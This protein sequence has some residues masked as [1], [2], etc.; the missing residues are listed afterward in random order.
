MNLLTLQRNL[1]DHLIQGSED[2]SL[3][4]RGDSSSRLAVYYDAYR[5][6]LVDCLRDTFERVWTWLGDA[7]F[8]TACQTH[9]E[10]HPPHAWT[11]ADYGSG[12]GR[13]LEDL[14]P[15]DPELAELAWLDWS[16]RRAF[17]GPDAD[18]LDGA[19][20]RLVDWNTAIVC[21]VPTLRS[22]SIYTNCAAIWTALSDARSPPAMQRLTE[23]AGLRVWR[24]GLTP[25]FRSIDALELHALQMAA[26]GATFAAMCTA[27]E[28][29]RQ[30]GAVEAAGSFLASWL[31][32]GLITSVEC[33]G[34]G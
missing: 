19:D 17:D 5:A 29:A 33:G 14:Y 24:V 28:S 22:T 13:T 10:L 34:S 8:E 20:C 2:I 6:Q 30:S 21:F 31:Q 25:R 26:E 1:R 4:I 11:L 27:I 9:I 18:S 32:D 15:N 12:F 7:R 16:L 23:A 3:E